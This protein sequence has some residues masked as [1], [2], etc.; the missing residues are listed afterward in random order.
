MVE[1]IAL[2]EIVNSLDSDDKEKSLVDTHISNFRPRLT[3]G[4][5]GGRKEYRHE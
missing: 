1:K 2:C 3:A 5:T 4:E